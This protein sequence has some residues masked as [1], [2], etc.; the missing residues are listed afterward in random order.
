MLAA[1]FALVLAPLAA[2]QCTAPVSW[3]LP[4]TWPVSHT[5]REI[6]YDTSAQGYQNKMVGAQP[7]FPNRFHHPFL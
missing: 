4:W 3:P 5:H 6:E 2:A 1:A 7:P